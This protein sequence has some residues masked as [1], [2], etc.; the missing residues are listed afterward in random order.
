MRS[1]DIF[2]YAEFKVQPLCRL[3]SSLKQGSTCRFLIGLSIESDDEIEWVLWSLYT[4]YGSTLE[5]ISSKLL[6][7]EAA[8]LNYVRKNFPLTA[9]LIY[10]N[11]ESST[12]TNDVGIPYILMSKATGFPLQRVWKSTRFGQTELPAGMKAKILFQLGSIAFKLSQ[13]RLESIRSLIE[14]NGSFRVGESLSRDHIL[15]ERYSLD[16]VPRGPFS[17]ETQ[18]YDSLIEV[19]IQHAEPLP[20]SH[21][22]FVAPVPRRELYDFSGLYNKACDLWND[23]VMVG[24]KIDSSDNRLDYII[25]AEAL[26]DMVPR[27]LQYIPKLDSNSFPLCH[28]DLSV[29]NIYIDNNYDITC[30]IDWAFCSSVPEAMALIPSWIATVAS[31]VSK[32]F[33]QRDCACSLNRFLNFDSIDDYSLF[34]TVWEQI[35]GTEKD[36]MS[37]LSEQRLLCYNIER[38]KEIQVSDQPTERIESG[39]RLL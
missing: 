19:L 18:F 38:Y 23:F 20:L 25:A 16:N 24:C 13:L 35:Y 29:N 8:A 6:E 31:R 3:A 17:S 1:N 22:C 30:I 37:Y 36:S 28:S 14:Q 12:K 33:Q 5:E 27:W 32:L 2:A 26:R 15:H 7:S 39:A 4:G 10:T 34:T 11:L 9:G 21:H